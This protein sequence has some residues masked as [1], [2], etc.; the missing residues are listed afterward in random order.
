VYSA[1]AT[2]QGL[3]AIADYARAEELPIRVVVGHATDGLNDHYYA[4]QPQHA[5]QVVVGDLG[6]TI[7]PLVP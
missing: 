6:D 5:D 1:H 3:H 7:C 4:T 2:V